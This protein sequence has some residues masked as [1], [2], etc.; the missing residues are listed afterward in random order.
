MVLHVVLSTR[1][2]TRLTYADLFGGRTLSGGF[3]LSICW[4]ACSR[5]DVR[6]YSQ[7]AWRLQVAAQEG[8]LPESGTFVYESA[9]SETPAGKT[10]DSAVTASAGS[11]TGATSGDSS[12]NGGAGDAGVE[13]GAGTSAPVSGEADRGAG[14]GAGDSGRTSPEGAGIRYAEGQIVWVRAGKVLI[15]GGT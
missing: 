7:L 3:P 4:L 14:Q 13:D 5:V 10:A 8:T 12:Q 11:A 1:D 9:E 6:A 15:A 2:A